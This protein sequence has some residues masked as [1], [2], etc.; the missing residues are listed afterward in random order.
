MD[1]KIRLIGEESGLLVSAACIDNN[2]AVDCADI[3]G[4]VGQCSLINN[5]SKNI[6]KHDLEMRVF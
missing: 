4:R 6:K 2:V 5:K 1:G 3:A